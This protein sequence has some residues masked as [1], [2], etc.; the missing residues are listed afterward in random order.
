MGSD[1]GGPCLNCGHYPVQHKDLSVLGY[2]NVSL[3]SS[4]NWEV[5]YNDLEFYCKIGTGAFGEV[6]QGK[7]WGGDVAIKRINNSMAED[8]D[9]SILQEFAQ[10]VS[11]LSSIRHPNCVLFIAATLEPPLCIVT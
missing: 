8:D 4:K 3:Y 7:L 11:V 6:W 2:S 10:E 1:E 9:P 5:G